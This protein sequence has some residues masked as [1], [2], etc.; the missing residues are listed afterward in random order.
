MT[1][2]TPLLSLS[3]NVCPLKT[4][5]GLR[6]VDLNAVGVV[7]LLAMGRRTSTGG[8]CGC[9][10]NDKERTGGVRLMRAG[11]SDRPSSQYVYY[12]PRL[13]PTSTHTHIH[14]VRS[15]FLANK[16][17]YSTWL[18]HMTTICQT[19]AVRLVAYRYV[20]VFWGLT[21]IHTN[22]ISLSIFSCFISISSIIIKKFSE[23]RIPFSLGWWLYKDR[24]LQV[25]CD[26][27]RTGYW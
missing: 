20:P 11:W 19:S 9:D 5:R 14:T 16:L 15:S 13:T 24:N 10:D 21:I 6:Q 1:H 27:Q 18:W 3:H 4:L 25:I 26:L 8:V 12:I 7:W 2:R 23:L 17:L 22:F